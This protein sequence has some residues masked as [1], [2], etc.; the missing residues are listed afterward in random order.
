MSLTSSG[1]IS[2]RV[3]RELSDLRQMLSLK[4]SQNSQ[5][6]KEIERIEYAEE[7][8][9]GEVIDLLNQGHKVSRGKFLARLKIKEVLPRVAWKQVFIKI[10]PK[11][12]ARAQKIMDERETN[13]IKY[14][15][16]STRE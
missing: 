8:L 16:L 11:G 13:K 1:K 3:L 12:E 9:N 2:Q 15:E 7:L 14:V 4:K 10:V 5:L 6:R